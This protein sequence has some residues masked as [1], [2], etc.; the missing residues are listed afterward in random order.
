MI[1]LFIA[2]WLFVESRPLRPEE[3][4]SLA[5]RRRLIAIDRYNGFTEDRLV[6]NQD[7]KKNMKPD[8]KLYFLD[9]SM[10][11]F[12]SLAAGL[13]KGKKHEW[14][15]FAFAKDHRIVAAWANKGIDKTQVSSA[16]RPETLVG[17]AEKLGASIVL[18]FHNHPNPNPSRYYMLLPSLQDD[19]SAKFF[20]SLF[21]IKSLTYLAFVTARGMHSQYACWVPDDF[22]PLNSFLQIVQSLNG[23][24]RLANFGL[25]REL[26]SRHRILA[27]LERPNATHNTKFAASAVSQS[28]MTLQSSS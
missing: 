11:E 10:K 2:T 26:R 22:M 13:L 17:F 20:G 8:G 27:L 25:R 23:A 9:E 6:I 3:E 18:Q 14:V 12:P 1:L 19:V 21:V 16:A 4:K 28:G 5:I 7:F 15:I 24:S